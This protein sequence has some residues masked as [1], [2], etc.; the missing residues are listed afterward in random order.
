MIHV[1]V[2]ENKIEI[3]TYVILYEVLIRGSCLVVG[4]LVNMLS[5][6]PSVVCNPGLPEWGC[7]VRCSPGWP[8]VTPG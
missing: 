2:N 7:V 8:V 5:H 1:A 6:S 3:T 4:Q